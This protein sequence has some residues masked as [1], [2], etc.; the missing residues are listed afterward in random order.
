MLSLKEICLTL[1]RFIGFFGF[2]LKEVKPQESRLH[3]IAAYGRLASLAT[4]SGRNFGGIL[5][6][7]VLSHLH[8]SS[9]EI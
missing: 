7:L 2:L 9:R 1:A 8:F 4:Y 5:I 3:P 6:C